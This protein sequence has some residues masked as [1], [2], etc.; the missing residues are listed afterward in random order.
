MSLQGNE[1]EV[2]RRREAGPGSG[3]A[4][5]RPVI[6]FDGVCELCNSAVG[7][8]RARDRAGVFDYLPY[9]SP[10]VAR[11]WPGLDPAALARALHVVAPDGRVR[12]GADAAPWILGRLP[13]W[14]WL[15][16]LLA[17]PGVRALARPAYAWVAARRRTMPGLTRCARED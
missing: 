6:L 3:P 15:A 4:G 13:G 9:Q 2:G 14:R 16:V 1:M 10:E 8:I 5:A 12:A 7:W 17:L 11:R